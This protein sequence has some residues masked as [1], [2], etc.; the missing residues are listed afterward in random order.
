MTDYD[1]PFVRFVARRM[2]SSGVWGV[3][4]RVTVT[5]VWCE[6]RRAAEDYA[7]LKNGVARLIG[8]GKN[9]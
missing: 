4:D 8:K 1:Q 2:G 7:R 3:Y 5:W 6:D 9:D